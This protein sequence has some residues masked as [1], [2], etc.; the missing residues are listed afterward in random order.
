ME[1]VR[2]EIEKQLN[3]KSLGDAVK[4]VAK[5]VENTVKY[6]GQIDV[7][8]LPLLLKAFKQLR[9][10]LELL[11]ASYKVLDGQYDL[12]AKDTIP[13]AFEENEIDSM[14]L[15]GRNFILNR[16]TRY[17]IPNELRD[18]GFKWL[19]ENN[20]GEL[21]K[22]Q[23]NAKSLTSALNSKIEDEGISPPDTAIKK[24]SEQYISVRKK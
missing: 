19:K 22:E 15:Y 9:E 3:D 14:S 8:D 6:F 13:K 21:I 12:L 16:T 23:V 5:A 2:E 1:T 4:A 10:Q 18:E 11:E 7:K 17:S 20:L 24:F